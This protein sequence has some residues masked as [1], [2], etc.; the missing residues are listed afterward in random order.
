MLFKLNKCITHKQ[1]KN[2]ISSQSLNENDDS[3][4]RLTSTAVE[5]VKELN[6]NGL[7]KNNDEINECYVEEIV[8]P[9]ESIQTLSELRVLSLRSNGINNFPN[10][11]LQLTTLTVL[12][13]SDNSLLTLPPEIGQLQR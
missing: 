9:G 12:D 11:V 6:L 5:S 8:L 2:T 1:L 10:S 4:Q 3:N 13:L 7:C